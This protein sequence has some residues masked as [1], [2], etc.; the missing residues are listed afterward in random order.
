MPTLAHDGVIEL[1]RDKPDFALRL[2]EQIFHLTTPPHVEV[3]V[4]DSSLNQLVP[5]EYRADL[6]LEVLNK[7][8]KFVLAIVLESQ[9]RIDQ[10]KEYSWPVYRA[11]S[12]AER[13]CPAIVMVVAVD[14]DV[15][16]WAAQPIDM[17]LGFGAFE[18]VVLGPGTLPP[19]TDK[20][21]ARQDVELSVLSAMAHGN[22]V[23]GLAVVEAALGALGTLDRDHAAV[24]FEI[25]WNVLREPMQRALEKLVMEKQVRREVKFPPFIQVLV[26]KGFHD[27]KLIGEAT[28]EAKGLREA[29]LRGVKRRGL[30]LND[31]QLARVQACDDTA[32]LGR[33][34][35]NVFDAKTADDLFR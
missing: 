4:A 2:L 13:E 22:G 34:L 20:Q 10:R 12:R 14:D 26:E 25:I 3:R 7:D 17:G 29:V 9:Q 32:T 31:E 8:G 5:I 21:K 15:A 27:G 11:V 30:S 28:G 19:I 23:V 1:F 6:V 33:W 24:Y 16:A 35:D 18:A